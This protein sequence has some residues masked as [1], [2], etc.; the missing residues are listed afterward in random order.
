MT[1]SAHKKGMAFDPTHVN[2]SVSH[3]GCVKAWPSAW[4]AANRCGTLEFIKD[5][6]ADESKRMNA[7]V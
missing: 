6:N 4:R 2:P 7:E 1:D 3:G 5:F